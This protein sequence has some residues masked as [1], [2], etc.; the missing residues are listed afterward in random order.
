M[1][2]KVTLAIF[3]ND[4][5]AKIGKYEL[6]DDGTKIKVKSGGDAHW[7]PSFDRDSFIELPKKKWEFWKPQ[8]TRIYFVKKKGK[9]CVNFKTETVSGPDPEELKKAVG[10]TMLNQI[11]KDKQDTTMIQWLTLAGIVFSILFQMGVFS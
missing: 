8:W 4:L 11:G 9:K 7:M 10:A 1:A 2:R 5:K 3:D 6:S